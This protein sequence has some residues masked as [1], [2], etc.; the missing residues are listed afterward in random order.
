[1]S[2]FTHIQFAAKSDVGR[3]RKNNEDSFGVFPESGVFCVA[4]GMGG[5]DDGEIA[6]AAVVKEVAT[7]AQSHVPPSNAGYFGREIA[8]ELSLSLNDASA[9]IFKRAKERH[10]KGC[11][12]TF[13]GVC[14]DAT[15]PASAI[16]L[17]VG[18]SRLYRVRGTSIRQ[19]TRDHS[20][21]ELI[22]AKDENAINPCFRGVILRAVG[23]QPSVEVEQTDLPLKE[24]DRIIL[25]SDGLSKMVEDRKL[26]AIVHASKTPEEAVDALV[27]AAN[28]AGGTDN[29]TAVVLF[30]GRLPP[31]CPG[32]SGP[33]RVACEKSR[34]RSADSGDS[35]TSDTDAA[36]D[37]ASEADTAGDTQTIGTMTTQMPQHRRVEMHFPPEEFKTSMSTDPQ[38]SVK[39]TQFWAI[40]TILSVAVTAALTSLIWLWA[41]RGRGRDVSVTIVEPQK[42]VQA[43][44]EKGMV[45]AETDV[46]AQA[47]SKLE[48]K[49]VVTAQVDSMVR[50]LSDD[51][52]KKQNEA[53]KDQ[54][55]RQTVDQVLSDCKAPEKSTNT[56]AVA[57]ESQIPAVED[58]SA[59]NLEVN[60]SA[61]APSS[62]PVAADGDWPTVVLPRLVAACAPTNSEAFVKTVRRFLDK[63]VS[64]ALLS[65]FRSI[66]DAPIPMERRRAIAEAITADVQDIA[67]ELSKY[68]EKR[69]HAI[70]NALSDHMT[71]AEFREKFTEEREGLA[72][73][74]EA[75]KRFLDLD[76]STADAQTACADVIVGIIKW[77]KP[78]K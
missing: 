28:E 17:H 3:K 53:E 70:D 32:L 38:S 73:F 34:S 24:G 51:L 33:R 20:A 1:M 62:A 50:N 74:A 29:I 57:S 76:P 42:T 78:I 66:C 4:D 60:V 75:S 46:V 14:F 26:S 58:R 10:L 15:A 64:G 13:V 6:S 54:P 45:G 52:T 23:V 7:C 68:S 18:D 12:S 55:S 67:R 72:A 31:A 56:A 41:I 39:R 16:A 11:G 48:S 19:I 77:F 8:A 40:V 65:R 27:A 22:G 25:C 5:G 35:D 59:S 69:L 43:P 47:E 63:G 37:F 9:W 61:E 30:V 2:T 44:V 49:Q 21:A 36:R 71:R